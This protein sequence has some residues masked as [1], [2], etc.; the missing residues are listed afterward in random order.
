MCITYMGFWI[1]DFFEIVF[2]TS[3]AVLS[4]V[5]GEKIRSDYHIKSVDILMM[6]MMGDREPMGQNSLAIAKI[7]SLL[8]L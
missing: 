8:H 7:I 2:G 4:L 1:L 5:K 3:P 6:Q